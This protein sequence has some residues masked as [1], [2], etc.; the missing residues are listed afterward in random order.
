MTSATLSAPLRAKKG[1][2]SAALAVS[3]K[4]RL[5]CK[6]GGNL[7]DTKDSRPSTIGEGNEPIIRRRRKC[8]TC[9]KISVTIELS[10]EYLAAYGRQ[11]IRQFALKILS[12]EKL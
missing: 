4:N 12:E 11:I 1:A 9:Q 7:M 3:T 2:R 8:R 5:A 10:E 6:C